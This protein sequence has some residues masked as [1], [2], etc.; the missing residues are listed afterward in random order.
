MHR[1]IASLLLIVTATGCAAS[2]RRELDLTDSAGAW[3]GHGI[4]YGPY[5]DG[6]SPNGAQPSAAEVAEDVEL[7]DAHFSV[8]RT[9]ATGD[10]ERNM[11]L[12]IREKGLDIKIVLGAWIEPEFELDGDR[13][14]GA[15]IAEKTAANAEQV[16]GAIALANEFPDVIIAVLVGNET[17]V[18]WSFHACQPETLARHLR[19]VRDAI[20]QPV[21]TADVFDWWYSDASQVIAAECDFIGLHAYALWN[22]QQLPQAMSWTREQIARVEAQHPGMPIYMCEIGWATKYWP[23]GDEGQW[24]K[25]VPGEDEQELFFRAWRDY[26]EQHRFPY[27]WFSAFDENWKN[28]QNADAVENHW[29]LWRADR[30]AKPAI[31]SEPSR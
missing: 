1:F 22:A 31:A 25:G 12:A 30:S 23:E 2:D 4:C 5:R 16:A 15:P 3:M 10:N 19:T 18:S 24:I 21:S 8:L 27:L 6:Q 29:G 20:E 7:L 13:Q 26:A 11:C 9:Y 14:P 17:Q 28:P